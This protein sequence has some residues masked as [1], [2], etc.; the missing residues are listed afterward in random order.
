MRTSC[1][2]MRKFPPGEPREHS[3]GEVRVTQNF[4]KDNMTESVDMLECIFEIIAKKLKM[5]KKFS[6]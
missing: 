4:I 6:E 1:A 2:L 5:K 3:L